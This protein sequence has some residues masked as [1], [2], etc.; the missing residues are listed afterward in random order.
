MY[1]T[2]RVVLA[3]APATPQTWKF[4]TV[5]TPEVHIS[6]VDGAVHVDAV[7]GNSV[8]FEVVREASDSVRNNFEV[9]VVA[10]VAGQLR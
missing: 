10:T 6:N 9:E 4:H 1:L 5:G 7:D 3:A 8:I 2:L